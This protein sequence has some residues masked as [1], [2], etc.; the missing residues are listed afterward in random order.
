MFF[1]VYWNNAV[2]NPLQVRFTVIVLLF[3]APYDWKECKPLSIC[4][5]WIWADTYLSL[6]FSLRFTLHY[7]IILLV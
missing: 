4:A 2:L 1:A 3:H 5:K 6:L 7:S